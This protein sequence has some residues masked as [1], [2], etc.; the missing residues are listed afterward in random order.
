MFNPHYRSVTLQ[1]FEPVL[2]QQIKLFIEGMLCPMYMYVVIY[3]SLITEI[4]KQRQVEKGLQ[5]ILCTSNPN[6][7]KE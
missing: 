4:M 2:C 6:F 1:N 5:V 7:V 3:T